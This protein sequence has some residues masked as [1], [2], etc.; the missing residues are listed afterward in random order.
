MKTIQVEGV[1]I[2]YEEI[3]SGAPLVAVHGWATDHRYIRSI[4]EPV[5]EPGTGWRRIYPD[6]P[7]RGLTPATEHFDSSEGILRVLLGFIDTVVGGGRLALAGLSYGGLLVREVLSRKAERIDGLLLI[8]PTVHG[9]DSPAP[10]PSRAVLHR[11]DAAI[12]QASPQERAVLE[13]AIVIQDL[14][15]LSRLREQ[16]FPSIE[17]TDRA[18]LDR[19]AGDRTSSRGVEDQT[20]AGPALFLLGRQDHVV[21]YQSALDLGMHFPRA[22]LAVIDGAG[23]F[24]AGVEQVGVCRALIAEWVDRVDR[25][26]SRPN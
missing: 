5:F 6:L 7:G 17:K 3:G 21:G 8:V 19:Y 15:S 20:F 14:D 24:L 10:L 25:W 4:L 9:D 22:T 11:E 12:E 2:H 1:S 13:D 18:F 26:V 23:H 16:F